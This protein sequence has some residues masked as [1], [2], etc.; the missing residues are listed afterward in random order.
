LAGRKKRGLSEEERALWSR[1]TETAEPLVPAG[2]QHKPLYKIEKKPNEV[3]IADPIPAFR[4][5][6]RVKKPLS[7]TKL[8]PSISEQL[9]QNPVQMDKKAYG[10]MKAGKLVPEG[11]LDLHGMTLEQAHPRLNRF[12]MD[13]YSNGK[14]LVLVITGKGKHKE[15][16]GPIP[17]RLGVLKHQVPQWLQQGVLKPIV[18]Q[19]TTANQK[20]GG[21]GAYY[22]YLRRPR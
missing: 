22:V 11:R 4:V 7:S 2:T 20:H 17:M 19:V 13:A 21:S 12:I 1:V 16:T 9:S 5:G 3:L 6:Q 8:T 15:D 18:L 10:K 14:R